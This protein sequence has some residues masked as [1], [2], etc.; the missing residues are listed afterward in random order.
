MGKTSSTKLQPPPPQKSHPPPPP[1]PPQKSQPPPPLLP[2]KEEPKEEAEEEAG[3][4][5]EAQPQPCENEGWCVCQ[6]CMAS[7]FQPPEVLLSQKEGLLKKEGERSAGKDGEYTACLERRKV[8]DKRREVEDKLREVED[9]LREE[10]LFLRRL[11]A[12]EISGTFSPENDM[13]D[14]AIHD[15]SIKGARY[16]KIYQESLAKRIEEKNQGGE[17]LAA[18]KNEIRGKEH[19]QELWYKFNK[20]DE[21]LDDESREKWIAADE[22]IKTL[23]KEDLRKLNET[24]GTSKC[25]ATIGLARKYTAP[26][27]LEN[28]RNHHRKN[29][30]AREAREA[31]RKEAREAARKAEK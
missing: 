19:V 20:L 26:G 12:E 14:K 13:R 18:F 7:K 2:P 5:A 3:E 4:E 27:S 21:K 15:D 22:S 30:E 31:A 25:S 16:E 8:E 11:K 23:R 28:S 1:P 6:T 10:E 9:K 29:L 24:L 17:R